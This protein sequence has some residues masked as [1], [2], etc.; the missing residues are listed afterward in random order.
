MAR[1]IPKY[2][3]HKGSG[4][5]LVQI[6]GRRIY[7]GKYDS[8]ESH[9]KY[10]RIVSEWLAAARRPETAS[11]G[12]AAPGV[13]ISINEL[14]LL[15]WKFAS[16]Y[17][18]KDGEP[19]K[20]LGC[21]RDALRPVRR[22]YGDTAARE[23]GPLRLKHVR[24][25]MIE[26][27]LSRGVINNRINRIRRFFKW[28]VSEE[29]IPPS[30]HE[31]LKTVSGLQPG[32]H[33]VRETD[34]V[35]PADIESVEKLL[36]YLAPPVRAMVQLQRLTGMRPGEVVIMRPCDIDRSR[37]V[38][39]YRPSDHKTRHLGH[40]RLV[41]LG[42][43]AQEVVEP[44]LDRLANAFLFSPRDADIWRRTVRPVHFKQNRKTP[45]YPSEL[46]TRKR[47]KQARRTKAKRN[48]R[49][50]YDPNSYRK[51]I[52]YAF[53]RA[54]RDGLSLKYW[55]PYMLRHLRATEV[56][57][58]SG[59]EAA[60]VQL[61]HASADVTQIYAERDLNLAIEVARQSG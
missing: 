18:V 47:A 3:L 37:D 25:H 46:K 27:D 56:R 13:A 12:Q 2:R 6:D 53:K 52:N 34:D 16:S 24:Q 4:Q 28:A 33:A 61:G 60:Q 20:E 40:D 35:E 42:P 22:L 23:F 10:E 21:M 5:A 59:L 7:L 43:K 51:S 29:Y 54:E 41:P 8:P 58:T 44:F 32:R 31:A 36:P 17:Y 14:L 11:R 30:V 50:R 45:V 38:W 9:Q 19:T 39:L 57:A 1:R 48:L 49:E 55:F 15:Y 26:N